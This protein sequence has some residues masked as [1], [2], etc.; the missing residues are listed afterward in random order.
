MDLRGSL[1]L[2]DVNRLA[3]SYH[4]PGMTTQQG[5]QTMGRLQHLIGNQ[6]LESQYFDAQISSVGIAD[7]ADDWLATADA[8]TRSAGIG[9]SA[10][11][12]QLVLGNAGE[13]TGRRIIDFDVERY[14]GCYFVKF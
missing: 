3:E 1:A 13:A 14:S 2:G 11:V 6:V 10:G 8:S 4:W 9:G 12:L 7:A 5:R